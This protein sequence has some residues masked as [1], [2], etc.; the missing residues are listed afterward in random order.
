MIVICCRLPVN[1]DPLSF[2]FEHPQSNPVNG[3]AQMRSMPC[4]HISHLCGPVYRVALWM[5]LGESLLIDQIT[6]QVRCRTSL[7]MVS[8]IT[9]SN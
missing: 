9:L 6:L 1:G 2:L 8:L 5:L 4:K 7:E 3:T